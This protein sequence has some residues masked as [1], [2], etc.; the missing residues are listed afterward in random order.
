MTQVQF[1]LLAVYNQLPNYS[2]FSTDRMAML[3]SNRIHLA[4]TDNRRRGVLERIQTKNSSNEYFELRMI[5]GATIC[6][7]AGH[8][9]R[10]LIGH[11]FDVVYLVGGACGIT[12]ENRDTKLFSYEWST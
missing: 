6:Q 12:T 1:N 11:P 9:E 7:L 8:A 2:V 3:G 4:L 10:Y 5:D